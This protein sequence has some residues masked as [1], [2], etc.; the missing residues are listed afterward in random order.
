MRAFH[1]FLCLVFLVALAACPGSSGSGSD[2][3][4][5]VGSDAGSDV[6]SDAGSDAGSDEGTDAATDAGSDEGPGTDAGTDEGTD[7]GSD[8]GSDEGTDE[9]SDE[10]SADTGSGKDALPDTPPPCDEPVCPGE[11]VPVDL[12]GDG[13]KDTCVDGDPCVTNEQCGGCND[14][15]ECTNYY[16]NYADGC[17]SDGVC[18]AS[19][20]ICTAEVDPVCGCNGETYG[21]SCSAAQAGVDVFHQG[22][23]DGTPCPEGENCDGEAQCIAGDFPFFADVTW[24]IL[25]TCY[26]LAAAD[27]VGSCIAQEVGFTSTCGDCYADIAAN[28]GQC[29]TGEG[30]CNIASSSVDEFTCAGCLLEHFG[31]SFNECSG[32]GLDAAALATSLLNPPDP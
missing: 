32:Y 22:P 10:G 4:A 7:E 14:D 20:D 17:A 11:E 15:E 3:G 19:P 28:L 16:C 5:D 29:T 1:Y 31:E 12:D 8:E 25:Q 2:I 13:C 30:N 26:A 23:C 6:S 24:Q 27:S 21:N 18:V 9:G